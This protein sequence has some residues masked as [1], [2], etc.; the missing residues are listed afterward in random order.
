MLAGMRLQSRAPVSEC[1]EVAAL[2]RQ[3][4]RKRKRKPGRGLMIKARRGRQRVT[5]EGDRLVQ[6]T[7]MPQGDCELDL[8]GGHEVDDVRPL[9]WA[10]C[11]R[12]IKMDRLT[13]GIAGQAKFTAN[14]MQGRQHS[15][16]QSDRRCFAATLRKAQQLMHERETL[17]ERCQ[18]VIDAECSEE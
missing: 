10:A 5:L 13:A 15:M 17:L 2:K 11:R 1:L 9:G 12:P 4:R 3:E 18:I 16:C 14:G 7:E 8:R 6:L